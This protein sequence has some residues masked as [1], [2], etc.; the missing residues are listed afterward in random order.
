VNDVHYSANHSEVVS[1]LNNYSGGFVSKLR[2]EADGYWPVFTNL[3][4]S[5]NEPRSWIPTL[6]P[7]K[8]ELRVTTEPAVAYELT[9]NGKIQ[10]ITNGFYWLDNKTNLKCE[11]NA[12]GYWPVNKLVPA[13]Q[14][15]GNLDPVI[16]SEPV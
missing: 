16:D 4:L 2:L 14:H 10:Q 7:K 13:A 12:N 1:I 11:I 5:P 9:V 8:T 15:S 6:I 3:S